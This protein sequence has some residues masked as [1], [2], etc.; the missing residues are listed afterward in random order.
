MRRET[1]KIPKPKANQEEKVMVRNYR[2]KNLW[3]EGIVTSLQYRNSWGSFS[4]SYDVVVEG[5]KGQR[6][7]LYVA[8]DGIMS[9]KEWNK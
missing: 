3:Q 6:V 1:I 4:W 9:L 7:R 5:Q 8:D 2:R